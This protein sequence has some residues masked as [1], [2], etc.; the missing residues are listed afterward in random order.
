[1]K[2]IKNQFS[3]NIDKLQPGISTSSVVFG[4]RDNQLHILV[5]K[6]KDLNLWM[7]PTGYVF[8]SENIE[9]SAKR[10]L[11]GRL[12]V[13]K[14]FLEQFHTFGNKDRATSKEENS[15]LFAQFSDHPKIQN[16]LNQRFISIGYIS[17]VRISDCKLSTDLYSDDVKWAPINDLPTLILDN[18]SIVKQAL[19]YL[20]TAYIHL[21]IAYSLLENKFTMKEVQTLYEQIYNKTTD[22]GN[23]QKRILKLDILKRHEKKMNGNA[24]RAPFLYSFNQE[25][26]LKYKALNQDIM[27]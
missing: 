13:K 18:A 15:V 6:L 25:K 27:S 16:W 8:T 2:N 22:R 20:K 10:I 21:P 3:K 26:Y 4:F 11:S 5:S 12:G 23:F 19:N 24:H 7:I 1:M 9:D 14:L 17:L